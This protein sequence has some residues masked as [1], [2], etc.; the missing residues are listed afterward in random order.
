MVR[1]QKIPKAYTTCWSA[2]NTRP[3]RTTDGSVSSSSQASDAPATKYNTA[4]N[5]CRSSRVK[6]SGGSPCHR[7]TSSAA[8]SACVYS[9]SRR[10]GKHKASSSISHGIPSP[11]PPPSELYQWQDLAPNDPIM[12]SDWLNSDVWQPMG[13]PSTQNGNVLFNALPTDISNPALASEFQPWIGFLE[14]PPTSSVAFGLKS[15][16][17]MNGK[18]PTSCYMLVYDSS[19]QLAVVSDEPGKVSLDGILQL[20]NSATGHASRYMTCSDCG[21]GCHRM[22]TLAIIYQ[23]Q[24]RVLC[25]ISLSPETF[26]SNNTARVTFGAFQPPESDERW[27]KRIMLLQATRDVQSNI[28]S[29]Y[30]K[31]KKDDEDHQN[32]NK[33]LSEAALVNIKWLIDVG[34]TLNK[35][36]FMVK[37]RLQKDDWGYY[38]Q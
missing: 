19:N 5:S 15:Q 14:P 35:H 30:H 13:G 8:P 17:N 1:S 22:I 38:P 29:F 6:C 18:C 36:L 3:A 12:A 20:L 9:V 26:L 7:C 2:N 21:A 28:D 16:E 32:G 25:E 27:L 10:R 31:S 11:R 4:C 33:K 23:R 37:S 24:V 34:A